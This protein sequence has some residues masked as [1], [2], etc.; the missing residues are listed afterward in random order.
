[1]TFFIEISPSNRAECKK[2]MQKILLGEM[3]IREPQG[4]SF[5]NSYNYFYCSN[6]SLDIVEEE[7]YELDIMAKKLYKFNKKNGDKYVKRKIDID[8]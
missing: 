1:M 6:C 2:C 4:S 7:L 8:G 5:N 3:R